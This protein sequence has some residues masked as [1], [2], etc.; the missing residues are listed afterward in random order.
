M[1]PVLSRWATIVP[2]A[3]PGLADGTFHRV[4]FKVR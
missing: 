4:N 3:V 2:A 1:N